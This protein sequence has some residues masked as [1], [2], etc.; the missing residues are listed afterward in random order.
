LGPGRIGQAGLDS[1]WIR[2]ER[3]FAE[4]IHHIA[5]PAVNAATFSLL[6]APAEALVAEERE[7]GDQF[8]SRADP[9]EIYQRHGRV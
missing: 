5:V 1:P 8:A 7:V 4:D 9:V 6:L 2:L 3:A